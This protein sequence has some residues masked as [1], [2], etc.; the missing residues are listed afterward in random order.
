MRI[1]RFI[2]AAALGATLAI[3]QAQAQE[4]VA[5]LDQLLELVR[6]G[7]ARDNQEHRQRLEEFRQRQAEQTQLLQE[8][9]ARKAA[10]EERSEMLENQFEENELLIADVQE[11]L[12]E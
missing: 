12:D 7:Q 2:A 3:A 8:A 1:Y 5:S 10:E 11:Q 9:E 4:N 6:Q